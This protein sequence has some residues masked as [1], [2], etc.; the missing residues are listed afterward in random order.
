MVLPTPWAVTAVTQR[1][2]TGVEHGPP[3]LSSNLP[4]GMG[5]QMGGRSATMT[6]DDPA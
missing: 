5:W 6:L 2:E 4:L 3:Y 1:Q